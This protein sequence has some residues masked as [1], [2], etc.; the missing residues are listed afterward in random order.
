M[1]VTCGVIFV[2]RICKELNVEPKR[3]VL[4]G[5]SMAD[6]CMGNDAGVGLTVGVLSGVGTRL[7]LAPYAD[8]TVPT[9]TEAMRHVFNQ[10]LWHDAAVVPLADKTSRP[11]ADKSLRCD[12]ASTQLAGGNTGSLRRRHGARPGKKA[13]LVIF[14]KD[15]TLICF[16]SMWTPWV[17]GLVA[18]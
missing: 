17:K 15:G 13:S 12:A 18:G 11:G 4:I 5:D 1:F 3:A 9:V 2:G 6:M 8:Y 7:D 10:S 14:D 16:H